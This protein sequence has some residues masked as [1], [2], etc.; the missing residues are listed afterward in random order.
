M[1]Q[2]SQEFR[3]V[4]PL[5]EVTTVRAVFPHPDDES[6]VLLM[7]RSEEASFN[8]GEW[9][10]TGG[11]LDPKDANIFKGV[12]REAEEETGFTIRLTKGLSLIDRY[13]ISDIESKRRGQLALVYAGAA[14]VISTGAFRRSKEHTAEAL[15][16]PNLADLVREYT[17][18]KH[19]VRILE[20]HE[21][22]VLGVE[23][24][25]PNL[26]Q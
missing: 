6:R 19:T 13:V 24:W 5:G 1:A 7:Q 11:K 9:E 17:L 14:R 20:L 2:S 23:D 22:G 26:D 21:H 10:F 18:T 8:P 16:L 4:Y 12:E 15:V 25:R 3:S